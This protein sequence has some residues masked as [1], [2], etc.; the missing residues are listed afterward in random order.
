MNIEI[1]TWPESAGRA[2]P[3]PP[4]K[5]PP[6]TVPP[7]ERRWRLLQVVLSAHEA[8]A[9]VLTNGGRQDA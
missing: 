1:E 2:A 4:D 3:A 6:D 9:E 8:D 7:P 5:A